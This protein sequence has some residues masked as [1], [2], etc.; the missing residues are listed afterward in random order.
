MSVA[1]LG[2]F[3]SS[4]QAPH[5]G[6]ARQQP[7]INTYCSPQQGKMTHSERG[8]G[9][10]CGGLAP[11]S[12]W[13]VVQRVGGLRVA[14]GPTSSHT[15]PT[16]HLPGIRMHTNPKVIQNDRQMTWA[17]LWHRLPPARPPFPPPQ[18]SQSHRPSL[19]QQAPL[20][21]HRAPRGYLADTLVTPSTRPGPG[22]L[23]AQD[24]LPSVA[25]G[26][27][28]SGRSGRGGAR[29]G[30][31]SQDPVRAGLAGLRPRPRGAVGEGG[32]RWEQAG[33]RHLWGD[34]TADGARLTDHRGLRPLPSDIQLPIWDGGPDSGRT[35]QWEDVQAGRAISGPLEP[36]SLSVLP[37][38]QALSRP[39][40]GGG[41]GGLHPAWRPGDIFCES[42]AALTTHTYSNPTARRHAPLG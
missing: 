29:E 38:E 4:Q 20:P 15:C 28:A 3:L 13:Q 30:A 27:L 25:A 11:G 14:Q 2:V 16:C 10:C 35:R 6:L 32:G 22:T 17:R 5:S 39:Q 19:G 33:T 42:P 40:A 37:K 36:L 34:P 9:A 7:F 8:D 41:G 31:S 21:C 12:T 18:L 26:P 24:P 1:R 23:K